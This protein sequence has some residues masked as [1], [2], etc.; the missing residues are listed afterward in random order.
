MSEIRV[1]VVDDHAILREGIC[2]LL[3]LRDDVQVVGE[4]SNGH[5]AVRQ[6]AQTHPHVVLMDISMPEMDG[7]EATRQIRRSFPNTQVLI[8][9]Q[10]DDDMYISSLLE[11]GACGYVLKRSGGEEIVNAIRNVHTKGAY[12]SPEVAR[13]IV[14]QRQKGRRQKPTG[15]AGQLTRREREVLALIVEGLSS[16]EVAER[17]CI[18]QKTAMVHRS[19]IMRKLDIHKS[20]ELVSYAIRRGLV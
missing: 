4:A 12:L 11:A 1:L 17:L 7:V 3:A 9:T 8:L 5:E 19:N 20:T 15:K 10:Y 14:A 18:A 2:S 16:R 13:Q 6:V